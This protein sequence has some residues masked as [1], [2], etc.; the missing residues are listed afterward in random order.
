MIALLVCAAAVEGSA[1]LLGRL[2]V[3]A[4][5]VIAV[6]GGGEL[7]R[8]ADVV[9]DMLV[10]DFDSI[11][12]EVVDELARAGVRIHQF[13]AEKDETDLELALAEARRAGADRVVVTAAFSGRLDHTLGALAALTSAADLRPRLAEPD[14]SG[15]ILAGESRREITL[16]GR[17]ATVSIVPLGGTATVSASGVR[18]PL[19]LADMSPQS[20]LGISNRITAPEGARITVYAGTIAV[21]SASVATR[22]ARETL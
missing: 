1:E 10:G 12:S 13:P 19:Q 18:W 16:T 6:D 2:S 17:D 14:M 11:S 5:L 8:D 22:P 15:W 21:I 4:D 7:C 9:P 20:T 3:D